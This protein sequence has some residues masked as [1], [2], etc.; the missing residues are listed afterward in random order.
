MTTIKQHGPRQSRRRRAAVHLLLPPGRLH[1]RTSAAPT[2]ASSRRRRRTRSR[3]SS[4]TRA[5][6]PR[7]TARSARTPASSTC[8][9][10]S[11]WA[12][13]SSFHGVARGRR[14][15]RRAPR[16]PRSGQQA[17]RLDARRVGLRAARTPRTTPRP[18]STWRLVRGRQGRSRRRGQGRRLGEQVQ[19]RDAQ[20]VRLDR[21]LGAEDRA[22]DGRGLVPARACSASAS[23]AP[24]RRRC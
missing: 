14:Q 20:P 17:A 22:D 5:C 3:R 19:V 23:A 1:P 18:S 21:R 15:R 9:S 11:A 6:A 8:S 16:L 13:A 24:P 12:C 10:R 4:P 7:A 2:S